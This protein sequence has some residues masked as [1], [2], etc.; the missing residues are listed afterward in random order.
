[1]KDTDGFKLP[2]E[3][4][5]D[6]KTLSDNVRGDLELVPTDNTDVT[7]YHN[8]FNAGKDDP[9]SELCIDRWNKYYCTNKNFLT[10]S[11]T[12]IRDVHK[13]VNRCDDTDMMELYR[14]IMTEETFM[15]KYVSY[16]EW[17]RLSHLN[18]NE[19][20]LH[21]SGIYHIISPLLSIMIPITI[22]II[23]FIILRITNTPISFETYVENLR[24][25]INK[26][27]FSIG[28]GSDTNMYLFVTVAI[29]FIQIYQ[30]VMSCLKFRNTIQ[31]IQRDSKILYTFLSNATE[32]MKKFEDGFSL[33]KT[34]N[35]FIN[36]LA[37]H[38]DV[39]D[40]FK[41]EL[42]LITSIESDKVSFYDLLDMGKKLKGFYAFYN[43]NKLITS[44][45]YSIYFNGYINNILTL[46]EKSCKNQISLCKFT[47]GNTKYKGG[48]FIGI[49][50]DT[51]K[52]NKLG[53]SNNIIIT[54]PNASGKTT[55]MKGTM[56]NNILSQQI[57]A[58]C[59]KGAHIRVYD[60]FHS[61][62]NIPDTSGRD[63]LFQAEARRCKDIIKCLNDTS[64][65]HLC[66][67][68]ELYSGTNP[69]EAISSAMAFISYIN[70]HPNTRF[71]LTTHYSQICDHVEKLKGIKN[72]HMHVT[73]SDAGIKFSY[74][75]EEGM[76]NTLG[77]VNVLKM[78][79]YPDE[80]IN[81]IIERSKE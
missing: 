67:F 54:G 64:A 51:I 32:R 46:H 47:K 5:T 56:F 11:Q 37:T 25:T 68:D 52:R 21:I 70:K 30:N 29:Y 17:D 63:S 19:I 2:I 28:G 13:Y 60:N 26:R 66:I 77:G 43:D 27:G 12:I 44:I 16:M 36:N 14:K 59:Y 75:I 24:R 76:S 33:V 8:L 48:Y 42:R 22:F 40:K 31:T 4:L 72:Y 74:K 35:P 10:D 55:I 65:S 9:Y 57:G 73:E 49:T 20:F 23:P 6:V 78:M 41:L 58:G 80:I 7:L 15:E 18:N 71:I 3:Y 38:R 69:N 79:D 53:L 61:Y 81:D 45:S 1:M 50:G 39:L 62:M 34:Y